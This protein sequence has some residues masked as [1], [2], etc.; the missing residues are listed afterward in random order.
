MLVPKKITARVYSQD[1]WKGCN[2]SLVVTDN[3]VVL[4]DVPP[5]ID[6]AKEWKEFAG[7]FGTIRYIVNTEFHH[8]HW[9]TDSV[10]SG[11][12]CITHAET[13]R[14]M[15]RMTHEFIRGRINVLYEKPFDYPDDFERKLPDIAF[16]GSQLDIRL[17]GVTL[18]LLHV[19]GHTAGQLVVYIPEEKVLYSSDAV[20]HGTRTPFHDA[21][22]T[23]KWLES[24]ELINALDFDYLIP[25]HGEITCVGKPGGREL[26][27]PTIELVRKALALKKAGRLVDGKIPLEINREIDPLYD[28]QPRGLY[29]SGAVI[30]TGLNEC[31]ETGSHGFLDTSVAGKDS[32]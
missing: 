27:P 17:G 14:G 25:G 28:T 6:K 3:G 21:V 26:I 20:Q 10:F 19:P 11:A 18:Q 32:N 9:I 29:R 13:Y 8:D 1:Q 2:C 31:F 23:D 5:E 15:E 16:E 4:L 30:L 22:F 12:T 7:T 24:L